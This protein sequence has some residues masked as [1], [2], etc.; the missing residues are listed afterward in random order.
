[1]LLFILVEEDEHEVEETLDQHIKEEDKEGKD[2]DREVTMK[3]GNQ[4][5]VA[6]EMQGK[7]YNK[8]IFFHIYINSSSNLTEQSVGEGQEHD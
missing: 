6:I 5:C 3:N 4:D 7:L 2:Q 1:M 8:H